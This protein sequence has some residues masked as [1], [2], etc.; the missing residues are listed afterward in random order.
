MSG[1]PLASASSRL[2]Q[3]QRGRGIGWLAAVETRAIDLLQECLDADPRHDSQVEARS[4]YYATLAL[5]LGLPARS[6]SLGSIADEY[7]RWL[8]LDVLAIMA[9]HGNA[10]ALQILWNHLDGSHGSEKIVW[11]LS[12][13]DSDTGRLEAAVAAN[14]RE[15]ELD[16][17]VYWNKQLPWKRW[18]KRHPRIADA[19]M[20][21][22]DWGKR[23]P[24]P[25]RLG[26]S[27]DEILSVDFAPV[28]ADL[29]D[30]FVHGAT[31]EELK[32]L[33]QAAVGDERPARYFALAV[34]GSRNDP[35]ALELA[36][37]T[38]AANASGRDR[39]TLYR[40]IQALEGTITLP[41]ARRWLGVGDS[42]DGVAA[43][44]MSLHSEAD[45]VPA[46]R[47]A[48]AREWS[49]AECTYLL[50]DLVEAL[51]RHPEQGPYEELR[52]T[53]TDVVYSYARKRAASS[54]SRVDPRFQ[55][56]FSTE[57]LWDCE[58]DAQVVGLETADL[59]KQ[60][61][62]SRVKALA[63]HGFHG[64]EK[65]KEVATTR[66]TAPRRH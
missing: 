39:A 42:R 18:A 23:R 19:R 59:Q 30:R 29:L 37:N 46:I 16:N 60:H 40:Y 22:A 31:S 50:C 36:E 17:M 2:G 28:P 12:E 26:A 15:P 52:L 21:V 53:F 25:P 55:E 7:T 51:G 3:L 10:D 24:D 5:E 66:L 48:F 58:P 20:R 4:E 33:R 57:C 47:A 32:R 6:L 8:R 13:L 61:V 54:M 44:L 1:L 63:H 35:C 14:V 56:L 34:L 41:L 64:A 38:F 11:H 9:K 49:E 43:T 65:I 45:D 62:A 27:L